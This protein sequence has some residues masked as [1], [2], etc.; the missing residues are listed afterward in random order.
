[1]TAEPDITY[2]QVL[3]TVMEEGNANNNDDTDVVEGDTSDQPIKRNREYV[4]LATDGLWDVFTN[5]NVVDIVD[6]LLDKATLSQRP[7]IA[8][9]LVREALR[10]GAYDNVTVIIIWLNTGDAD[11]DEGSTQ[12]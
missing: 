12:Q 7:Q 10:R 8:E 11:D 3:K 1:M 6:L 5:Q 9:V 4:V 2:T